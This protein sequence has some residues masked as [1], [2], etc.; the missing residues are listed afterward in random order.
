MIRTGV[1][2]KSRDLWGN[3]PVTHPP[4]RWGILPK[5]NQKV[6][7]GRHSGPYCGMVYKDYCRVSPALFFNLHVRESSVPLWKCTFHKCVK[8]LLF[9]CF[10]PAQRGPGK[11]WLYQRYSPVGMHWLVTCYY[12]ITFSSGKSSDTNAHFSCCCSSPIPSY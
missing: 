5:T 4:G 9:Q 10:A 11:L 6:R 3:F 1:G 12:S 2:T 8:R 7:L